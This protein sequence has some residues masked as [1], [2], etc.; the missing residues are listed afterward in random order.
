MKNTAKISRAS[1]SIISIINSNNHR[2]SPHISDIGLIETDSPNL[3]EIR[4]Y[5]TIDIRTKT[6]NILMDLMKIKGV[7]SV[8]LE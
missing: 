2:I 8:H 4:Y 7:K 5:A 1:W 3:F 6:D